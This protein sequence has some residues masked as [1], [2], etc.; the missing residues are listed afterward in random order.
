VGKRFDELEALPEW[1]EGSFTQWTGGESLEEV[2]ER[3]LAVV[4]R[5]V[6]ESPGRTVCV[7]GHGGMTRILLSHYLGVLPRLD[8]YPGRNTAVSVLVT[9]GMAHRIERLGDDAH[10]V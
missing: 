5:V 3:G 1:R 7:V 9:D 10:L 2:L 8:P 6:A 4:S